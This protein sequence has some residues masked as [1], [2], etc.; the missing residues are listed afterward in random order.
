[1]KGNICALRRLKDVCTFF[2]NSLEDESKRAKQLDTLSDFMVS[3]FA[4]KVVPFSAF[5]FA[6]TC[7]HYLII[8]TLLLPYSHPACRDT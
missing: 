8:G 7:L 2:A 5:L 4:H 1:M 6:Q 3:T